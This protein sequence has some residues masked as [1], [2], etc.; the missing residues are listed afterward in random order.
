MERILPRAPRGEDALGAIRSRPAVIE[1]AVRTALVEA[2]TWRL[3]GGKPPDE[4][5]F[6]CAAMAAA[7]QEAWRGPAAL[8]DTSA[9]VHARALRFFRSPLGRRLINLPQAQIVRTGAGR[10]A[11][12]V[13]VRDRQE[14]LHLIALTVLRRP[15]DIGDFARRLSEETLVAPRERLSPLRIH[16]YSLATGIRYE[17]RGWPAARACGA[18][19]CSA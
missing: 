5:A 17:Y 8:V 16:V 15:L 12:D 1:Y 6:A 19:A 3:G 10:C 9:A 11:A 13:V 18:V 4:G 7:R 2:M 14:R